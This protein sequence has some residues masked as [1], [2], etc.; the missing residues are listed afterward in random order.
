M[1]PDRLP[2]REVER[3]GPALR[4]GGKAL[5]DDE[6]PSPTAFDFF[7][8]LV[9]QDADGFLVLEAYRSDRRAERCR[10]GYPPEARHGGEREIQTPAGR[11]DRPGP[12]RLPPPRNLLRARR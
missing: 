10:G 1:F 9:P 8:L 4:Q 3:L 2:L 5:L 12:A 7:K 6:S 11:P